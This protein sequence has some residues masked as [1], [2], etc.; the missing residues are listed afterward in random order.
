[1]NEACEWLCGELEARTD[2][3]RIEARGTVRLALKA[4]GFDPKRIGTTSLV[5]VVRVVLARELASR[6]VGDALSLC[7]AL[8]I[9]LEAGPFAALGPD[10]NA[11]TVF[12]RLARIRGGAVDGSDST[13]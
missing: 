9:E 2:L 11:A 3:K 7:E 4:A 10:D 8:A 6:K 13:G 12:S 5:V 1:M